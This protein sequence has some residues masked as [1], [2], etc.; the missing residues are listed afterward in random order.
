MGWFKENE[1]LNIY[2]LSGYESPE[3]EKW[4]N[5]DVPAFA[6]FEDDCFP[7]LTSM[8]PVLW[9]VTSVHS[10]T[11]SKVWA[12]GILVATPFASDDL[13]KHLRSL[14]M[15]GFEGERVF[16]RFYDPNVLGGMLP[17]F[18]KGEIT[19]F[20]GCIHAI[21]L[22]SEGRV[23]K[24]SHLPP[25]GWQ[26][27]DEPWWRIHKHHLKHCYSFTAHASNIEK[28]CWQWMPEFV[29]RFEDP[30]L[31]IT[32]LLKFANSKGLRPSDSELY[33]FARLIPVEVSSELLIEKMMLDESYLPKLNSWR[34]SHV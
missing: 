13:L 26:P 8:S 29:Q 16:F 14:L 12:G 4:S 3:S 22:T 21:S 33:V 17:S 6:L 27:K 10:I 23:L 32:E 7:K 19:E 1:N 28:A 34:K 11:D 30:K 25:E 24:E 20:L 31:K 15:A 9:D 18:N 5:M 2:W